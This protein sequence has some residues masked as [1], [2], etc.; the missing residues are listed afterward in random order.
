MRSTASAEEQEKIICCDVICH[1]IPSL[2]VFHLYLDW[3]FAGEAVNEFTFRSKRVGAYAVLSI[4]E[5]G[6]RYLVP[7]YQDPFIQGYA[8]HHLFLRE[9]CHA[10]PFQGIPRLGDIS[11]GDFW[12]VP[13]HLYDRRGVS[14]VSANTARGQGL[15]CQIQ[16]KNR[17]QLVRSNIALA[18]ARNPRLVFGSWPVPRGRRAFLDDLRKGLTFG[19]LMEKH[20]P[21]P[22]K[23]MA[24]RALSKLWGVMHVRLLTY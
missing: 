13:K 7:G 24:A 20:Y 21:G 1:G 18:A 15:L 23:K 2:R 9:E 11:L 22:V 14:L 17:I 16:R 19:Q 8:V 12:G 6:K 3:L 4:S 10:C 5:S